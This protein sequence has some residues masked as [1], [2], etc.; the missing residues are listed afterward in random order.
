MGI[1]QDQQS[2]GDLRLCFDWCVHDD[3]HYAVP[4]FFGM[5]QNNQKYPNPGESE[6]FR[7][8]YPI[9]RSNKMQMALSARWTDFVQAFGLFGLPSTHEQQ[10]SAWDIQATLLSFSAMP[11]ASGRP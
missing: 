10:S 7:V 11:F 8:T 1:V 6:E 3:W 2:S 9:L 5:L 4:C